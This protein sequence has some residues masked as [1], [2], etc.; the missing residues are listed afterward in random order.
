MVSKV[1]NSAIERL[2]EADHHLPQ[3]EHILPLLKRGIGIHHSGLLPILKEAIEILFQEGLIK[4][5][6]ATETFSIGLNMPAKT[7]VFTGVQKFDGTETRSLSGGEYTQMSGR[8]GRRGLDE[9]GIVIM[10]ID[11][12]IEPAVTK[13]M[14]MGDAD[15][16]DSAFHLSYNMILNLLRVEGI[17]PEFMLE[18]SFYQHQNCTIIPQYK[19]DL[20]SLETRMSAY[21]IEDE[22]NVKDY[23]EM[24][25]ELSGYAN[26]I[27]S[28]INHPDHVLAFLQPGRLVHVKV[29]ELDFGWG[30]VVNFSRRQPGKLNVQFADHESVLVEVLVWLTGDSPITTQKKGRPKLNAGILPGGNDKNGKMEIITITLD[31]L[32]EIGNLKIMVPKEL[33][34]VKQR[35]S[36]KKTIDEIKQHFPDGVAL[37]DPIENMKI[38]DDAFFTLLRKTEV[39][40]CRVHDN[41]LHSAPDRIERY[42]DYAEKASL[43]LETKQVKSKLSKAQSVIQ[44]EEL[45]YRKRVLRQLGFTTVNDVVELKGRVACEISSGD[46]LVLTELIFS[47]TLSDLSAEQCSALLSC[48]VFDELTKEEPIL[49]PELQASYQSVI[50]IAKRVVE[51]SRSCKL[52]LDEKEYLSK[53]K[54]QLMIV[55]YEWCK[56]ATFSQICKL[57]KVYE[58]SLIRL[59]R[60]LEELMRQMAEAAKVIGNQDLEEKMT[61][62]IELIHRD[63][64]SVESLYL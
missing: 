47:G 44:L 32:Y 37:L 38:I 34:S 31:S 46:V 17:S 57:T 25:Q 22:E 21:Q 51:V 48:F 9:R 41:P 1:F 6:F 52:P 53:F 45:R 54:Y 13:K 8:A 50:D 4:V 61:K 49:S 20:E 27:R 18:Q 15:R 2:S 11:E 55:V 58:G 40:E 59:F 23:Y 29:G 35:W 24:L 28:T 16:L 19:T 64:V 7:V 36:V 60:R 39:L 42:N 10:M 12:Q 14:V 30:A 56:G 3:I 33:T 26:D 63:L 5:L 43:T 62:G